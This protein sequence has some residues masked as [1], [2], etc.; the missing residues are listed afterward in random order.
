MSGFHLVRKHPS[1][2]QIY[3]ESFDRIFKQKNAEGAFFFLYFSLKPL[4]SA[5]F[6]SFPLS[7]P[8]LMGGVL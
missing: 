5:H 6:S 2:D 1:F 4:N 8:S 3:V 7:S